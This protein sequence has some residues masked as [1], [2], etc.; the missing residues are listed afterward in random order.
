MAGGG[1][2]NVSENPTL[3][4]VTV[5]A[6]GIFNSLDSYYT[7]TGQFGSSSTLYGP[8]TNYGTIN[9]TNSGMTL[10]NDNTYYYGCLINQAGGQINFRG[11]TV[12]SGYGG[13]DYLFRIFREF[14]GYQSGDI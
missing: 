2:L 10:V 1:T 3:N 4:A 5:A 12:I 13:D 6:G 9:L 14:R 11:N 7:Q 8:L